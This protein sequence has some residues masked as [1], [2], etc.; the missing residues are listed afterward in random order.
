MYGG[1]LNRVA[2]PNRIRDPIHGFI[3]YD[4]REAEII[5]HLYFQRLRRIKQLGFTFYVYPGANHT[6]FE[7]SLGVMEL[8]TKALELLI[9]KR[10]NIIRKNFKGLGLSIEEGVKVARLSALLHDVG[11]F[12]FSHS[13]EGIYPDRKKH[14]DASAAIISETGLKKIL[15][16]NFFSGIADYI[17]SLLIG[18]PP[19]E[20]WF[21]KNLLSGQIDLDRTDY[22]VRDSLFCGVGYG[23]FDYNRFIECLTIVKS[24]KG[25][26]EIAVDRGGVHTI[27]SLILARYYMF[28]QVY[29]HRIR[30][31]YDHYFGEFLKGWITTRRGKKFKKLVD[32][33]NFDDVSIWRDIVE[34]AGKAGP[35]QK[36]TARTLL[37][38][39]R[40]HRWVYETSDHA[41]AEELGDI[42]D[43]KG[44]LDSKYPGAEVF[45]IDSG[46]QNIHKFAVKPEE[47]VPLDQLIVLDRKGH[48][49]DIIN[50]SP[51]LETLPKEFRVIRLY[52]KGT[53][54]EIERM[55]RLVH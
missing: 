37:E 41:Q 47:D 55:R 8:V 10:K 19:P 46:G 5:D 32:V 43:K 26:L 24:R 1:Y 11:H 14:E 39:G 45:I 18:T 2:L 33:L 12:A 13:G 21:I 44:L 15:E 40:H 36:E 3:H 29:F 53:D 20:L 16:K 48:K 38:R 7:H 22:L 42:R 4:D 25:S 51:V 28:S 31:L 6:R 49:H 50:E 30:S 54:D 52:A 17:I 23:N 27:E 35:I 9:I 34:T